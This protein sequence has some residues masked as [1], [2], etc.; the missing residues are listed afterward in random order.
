MWLAAVVVVV[1]AE[2]IGVGL[3]AVVQWHGV[4][5]LVVVLCVW[6]LLVVLVLNVPG[7]ATEDAVDS[8]QY[9]RHYTRR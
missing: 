1:A 5:V 2:D 8:A 7:I 3:A 4:V 6:I 9:G